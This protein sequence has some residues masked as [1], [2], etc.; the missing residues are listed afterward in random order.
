MNRQSREQIIILFVVGALALNY[1][2]LAL[3]DHRVLPL[4]I[5][6]LYLYLFVLWLTVIVLTAFIAEHAGVRNDD[7]TGG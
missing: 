6:L 7:R 5:P 2:I 3:F 4:G 1:P